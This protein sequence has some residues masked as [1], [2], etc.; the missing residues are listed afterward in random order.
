MSDWDEYRRAK[1]A[2]DL[3]RQIQREGGVEQFKRNRECV[4][5]HHG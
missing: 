5:H 1:E 3:A 4:A 2:M